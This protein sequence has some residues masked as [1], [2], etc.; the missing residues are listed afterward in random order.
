M[1]RLLISNPKDGIMIPIPQYPLYSASIDLCEGCGIPYYLNEEKGWGLELTELERSISAARALGIR[2]RAL[3]IINP[4]NPTGQC[5]DY[6]NME[7]IVDFCKKNNIVLMA[8]EVYQDNVYPK[9]KKFVSFKKVLF[10]MGSRYEGLELVSFHSVS[11]GMIGECGKRGGYLEL[12]NF[13]KE[14]GDQLYKLASIG[15]CPNVVGQIVVDLM[16][17]PPTPGQESYSLYQQERD[18]IY[19]SLRRRAALL[20]DALNEL[21]G[22]TCNP[23]EGAM[24][25]FPRVRLPPKAVAAAAEVNMVPD[26]FYCV[27]L[28][29]ATGVC[30][31]PGSGF[32]QVDGTWH[33]R[34]TFLPGEDKIQ[35]VVDR[36]SKFHRQFMDKYR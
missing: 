5:L 18:N 28:L 1:L 10:D 24:Y 27:A 4:G 16:V 12:V 6:K 13:H 26:T 11:K 7:G 33:F 34:T 29:D 3:V 8:D 23:S 31:V 25:A 35:S 32:G 17:H 20:A 15:L 14:V 9:D 21:E 36:M 22:V 30:V 19:Q 2:P